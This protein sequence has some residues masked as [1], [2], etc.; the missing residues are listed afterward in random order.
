MTLPN[1]L[2]IGAMKAGTTSLYQYL[3]SHP[4]VFM[5]QPKELH[6][7][8]Y[9]AGEDTAWYAEHFA[10][11]GAAIAVGEASASYTTYPDAE[12]V[13]GRIAAIPDVRLIYLSGTR[14]TA[15]APTTSND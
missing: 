9:R 12:E 14:S 15:C 2:I 5:A 7:F 13:P 1:F 11:A 3:G 8:S 6:F 4:Q 10:G